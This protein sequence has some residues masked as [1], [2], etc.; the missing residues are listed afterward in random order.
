MKIWKCNLCTH[1]PYIQKSSLIRHLVI[2]HLKQKFP[3]DENVKSAEDI[4]NECEQN[5]E[6]ISEKVKL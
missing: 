5:F 6:I 2:I 3:K 1:K 4:A